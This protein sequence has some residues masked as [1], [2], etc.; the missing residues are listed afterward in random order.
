MLHGGFLHTDYH[1]YHEDYHETI[2]RLMRLLL[3]LL[4]ILL[5]V[6]PDVL[7][8]TWNITRIVLFGVLLVTIVD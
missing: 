8:F 5:G 3:E 4:G 1:D 2:M 6:S 7:G